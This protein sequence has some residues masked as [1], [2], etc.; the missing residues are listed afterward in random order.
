MKICWRKDDFGGIS[1]CFSGFKAVCRPSGYRLSSAEAAFFSCHV[2]ILSRCIQFQDRRTVH[3][4][5]NGRNFG[6]AACG[7]THPPPPQTN[8]WRGRMPFR[9][10][11]GSG[12]A[13]STAA[14]VRPFLL[15]VFNVAPSAF[16]RAFRGAAGCRRQTGCRRFP[17]RGR[18]SCRH[19]SLSSACTPLTAARGTGSGGC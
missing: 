5:R 3:P 6:V 4:D 16:L 19:R 18:Q 12:P 2:P 14:D 1:L 11:A 13:F 10:F 17:L 7:Y 9:V 15:Y 8:L